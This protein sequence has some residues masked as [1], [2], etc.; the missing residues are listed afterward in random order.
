M[1]DIANFEL[2][3]TCFVC[4]IEKP[5]NNKNFYREKSRPMGLAYKCISCDKKLAKLKPKRDKRVPTIEQKIKR[6][7]TQLKYYKTL[8]TSFHRVMSYKSIDKKKGLDFDLTIEW[9]KENIEGKS[10]YYCE[11]AESRIGCDR[12]DNSQGHTKLNVVPCCKLCNVT[13]MNN[14]THDEMIIIGKTI[15]KIKK[16][17]VRSADTLLEAGKA[18]V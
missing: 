15:K 2:L 8:E 1:S 11:D 10:C 5:L 3:R 7:V 17:R 4:R 16:S 18:Y 6:K 14:F 12:I 9:Y 13:R